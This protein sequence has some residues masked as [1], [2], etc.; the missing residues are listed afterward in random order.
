MISDHRYDHQPGDGNG[1]RVN[2]S[3]LPV[4]QL[5]AR[6]GRHRARRALTA[7]PT[8]RRIRRQHRDDIGDD[9]PGTV[10]GAYYLLA[11]ADAAGVVAE[12]S[13]SNNSES[14]SI[15]IGTDL[16]VSAF[17]APSKGGAR[18][19]AGD[20]RDHQEPGH[21][22]CVAVGNALLPLRQFA[23]RRR[24]HAVDTG[25]RRPAARRGHQPLGVVSRSRSR[26]MRRPVRTYDHREGRCHQ[27]GGGNEQVEQHR[28][29]P[30]DPDRRQSGCLD[31]HRSR[32]KPA[33]APRSRC[34]TPT[35]NQGAGPVASSATRFYLSVNSLWDA[36]DT[37]LSGSSRRSLARHGD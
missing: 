23:V 22:I 8:T 13:E 36:G 11:V 19:A 37:L 31:L 5:A 10:S 28:E 18:T 27:R 1:R 2:H 4:R 15:Q 29:H 25:S 6:R 34:P 17:T 9:S 16:V 26:R 14:R 12:T 24:R 33:P 21:R 3:L 30:I 20:Q 32:R 35:I 7:V